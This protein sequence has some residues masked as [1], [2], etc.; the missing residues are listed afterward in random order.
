MEKIILASASPRRRELLEQIGI[1]FDI[2]VSTQAE[3]DVDKTLPPDIYV[4]ELALLKA[5]AVAKELAQ[6]KRKNSIIIAADT[7]VYKDN[8]IFGKP[9]DENEAKA[10]LKELS[11]NVHQV[12]TGVCVMR[13]SDGYS[14]SKSVKTSV[15]FKNLSDNMIDAYINTREPLDKAGAYGIQGMGAV[16]IDEINGDYFNVVGLP[17]SCL[18]DILKDE[19]NID[20]FK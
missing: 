14:V 5:S 13:L 17:L 11:G 15:K 18:Y 3:E 12:Y 20:I 6:S 19:F 9:K 2:I 10:I 16:L 1:N 8:K 7:I 4:S